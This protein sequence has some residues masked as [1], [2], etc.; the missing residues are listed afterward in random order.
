MNEKDVK[1]K[2]EKE[3]GQYEGDVEGEIVSF[4]I[5]KKVICQ[6]DM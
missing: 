4:V 3:G 6:S 1:R 2:K 5:K